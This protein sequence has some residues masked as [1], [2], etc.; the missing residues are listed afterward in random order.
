[1][2]WLTGSPETAE[3]LTQE[4]FVRAW[5]HLDRFEGRSTLRVWLHRIA[6][7][8]FLRHLSS[9]RAQASLEGMAE[10]ADR[11][12]AEFVEAIELREVIRKL[13]V[14]AAEVAILHYLQGYDCREIAAIIGATVSTV[15]YRLSAARIHL[16]RELGEGDLVYLNEP[17]APMRQ[18]NWLTLDQVHAL[19]TRLALGG[20][21]SKEGSAMERREFL[22]QAAVG[23]M[24]FRMTCAS[25]SVASTPRSAMS[26]CGYVL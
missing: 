3:D 17:L 8:E 24:R 22:R 14:E 1:M 21:A 26:T 5:Q 12:A 23:L 11:R 6:H 4:T 9:Q 19:E 25:R 13:S 15:K 16:R 2:L 10:L 20:C 7:R 18:W